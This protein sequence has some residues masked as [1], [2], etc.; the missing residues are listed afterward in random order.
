MV[1]LLLSYAIVGLAKGD[2]VE[3]DDDLPV[4]KLEDAI[5]EK[6]KS[7]GRVIGELQLFLAKKDGA[8]L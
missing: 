3:I 7:K 8:W 2:G 4:W 5:R 6:E 1:K